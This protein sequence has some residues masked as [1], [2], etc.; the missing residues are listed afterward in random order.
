MDI[1]LT[2]MERRSTNDI[3]IRE[4]AKAAATSPKDER[5][6]PLFMKRIIVSATVSFAPDEMPRT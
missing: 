6:I 3:E 2:R 1:F 4:P 5:M